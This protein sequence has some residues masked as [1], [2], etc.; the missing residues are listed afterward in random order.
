ML[1]PR[2]L[3][4]VDDDTAECRAVPTHEFRQRV[5]HDVGPMFDGPHQDRGGNGV[6][7]DQRNA[8]LV[9]HLR[10]CLDVA[11]VACRIAD[12]LREHRPG[13]VINELFNRVRLIR[14]R[15]SDGDA[16]AWQHIGEQRVSRAIELGHRHDIAPQFG[17][18]ECGVVD[19]GL[20]SAHAESLESAL[21]CRDSPLKHRVGGIGDA[22]VAIPFDLEVE[23]RCTVVGIVER[24]RYRLING[25]SHCLRRRIDLIP[26]VNGDRFAFHQFI[27][28][29]V[30]SSR[31][32][33]TRYPTR[34]SENS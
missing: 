33:P 23:Q 1:L 15:E 29:R 13:L 28:P 6:I 19:R 18:V 16:L 2:E 14:R 5:H 21:E 17:D 12:G 24:V 25:D 10:K 22:A 20:P 8:M 26:S 32:P 27:Q 7:D 3:A 31:A 9:G 11:N 30:G 4:A 34:S